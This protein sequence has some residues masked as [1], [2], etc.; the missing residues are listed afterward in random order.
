MHALEHT[1]VR[2][3]ASKARFLIADHVSAQGC[4][5]S[6][7]A[8]QVAVTSRCGSP[9]QSSPSARHCTG[10]HTRPVTAGITMPGCPPPSRHVVAALALTQG[11]ETTQRLR[12]GLKAG[13]GAA[14]HLEA[15]NCGEGFACLFRVCVVLPHR[16]CADG[17]VFF[18]RR[19]P[20]AGL[21]G[22]AHH[23]WL[24]LDPDSRPWQMSGRTGT[25]AGMAG[26]RRP[27]PKK[28]VLYMENMH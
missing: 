17:S 28:P 24:I 11:G 18:R 14:A 7:P 15:G 5:R 23:L 9:A 16:A 2:L 25:R 19:L 13:P 4:G 21:S 27:R 6:A 20:K 3:W 8:S 22:Y 10:S 1:S 12:V 26:I